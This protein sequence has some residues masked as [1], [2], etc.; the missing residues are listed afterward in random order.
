M[1]IDVLLRRNIEGLGHVG[2]VVKVR[3]GYARNFLVPKGYASLVTADAMGRITKDKKAEAIRQAEE[4]KA[5]A[6][7]AEVL[8]ELTV[9]VEARAGEDGHLYGSV[10][11]RQVQ[12]ALK[13]EG[14]EF[15]L[16]QIRFEPFRELG[17]YEVPIA[18]TRDHVVNTKLWVVQDRATAAAEAAEAAAAEAAAEAAADEGGEAPPVPA[19]D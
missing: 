12:L 15:D 3:N 11:P 14:F 8:S 17:Q 18:L 1:A 7:L 16:R 10:G 19:A 6:E 9:T 5:R 2:Q 13:R 4:A